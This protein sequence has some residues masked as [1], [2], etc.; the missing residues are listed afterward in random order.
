MFP[1]PC[2]TVGLVSCGTAVSSSKH[3]G[4][5]WFQRA[6]FWF[7]LTIALSPR[8]S[9]SFRCLLT[10]FRRPVHVPSWAVGPWGPC[11]SWWL[12]TQLSSLCSFWL[13]HRF[14]HDHPPVIFPLMSFDSSLIVSR[15]V[16]RLECKKLIL[17]TDALYTDRSWDQ[18]SLN[19]TDCSL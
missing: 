4:S 5:S 9:E 8:P 2:L 10:N 3:C 15:V 7:H 13:I 16:E 17:C 11:C 14:S 12:E 19:N 1:S 18:E 6:R